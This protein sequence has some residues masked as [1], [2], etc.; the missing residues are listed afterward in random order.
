[1]DIKN[2]TYT[3]ILSLGAVSSAIA[4]DFAPTPANALPQHLEKQQSMFDSAVDTVDPRQGGLTVKHTDLSIPGPKGLNI[5]VHRNYSLREVSA[6]LQNSTRDS[7]AW[8][9]LGAGWRLDVAPVLYFDNTYSPVY[10]SLTQTTRFF[11]HSPI[12]KICTNQPADYWRRQL[13]VRLGT[14]EIKT[15]YISKNNTALSKD[16]WRLTCKN[17]NLTLQSPDGI[18]HDFGNYK[19]NR[20]IGYYVTSNLYLKEFQPSPTETYVNAIKSY[21]NYGNWITYTYQNFGTPRNSWDTPGYARPS[22]D[23]AYSK[24]TGLEKDTRLLSS[25]KSNDG[26]IV[27][28]N[29]NTSS[30]RLQKISDNAGRLITY[31][32]S[33]R[34]ALNGA[35]LNQV[36]LPSGQTWKYTYQPGPFDL[37]KGMRTPFIINPLN[38]TTVADRKLKKITYP[39]GG[40]VTYD[41]TFVNLKQMY[42][43][44]CKGTRESYPLYLREERIARRTLSSG[45]V[46]N[47]TF[48]R[49]GTGK[50]DTTTTSGPDGVHTQTFH[51][52]GYA[53]ISSKGCSMVYTDTIWRIGSPINEVLPGNQTAKYDWKQRTIVNSYDRTYELGMAVDRQVWAADLASKTVV[54]DG[55]SYTNSF[56]GYDTY[57]NPSTHTETGPNGGGR[58]TTYTWFNLPAKWIIG[59]PESENFPG[60]S[61]TRTF[62]D[63]GNVLSENHNGVITN[64]TYDAQGNLASKTLPGKRVFTFSNYKRGIPQ[65]EVQPEGIRLTRVVDNA[66]NITSQ[67]NGEGKTTAYTYDGLG[68]VTSITPPVGNPTSITYTATSKTSKRGAL[69]EITQYDP[70]GRV[71]SVT[72]G[73]IITRYEYDAMGRQTFVSDPGATSGTRYKYDSLGRL[74]R[75]THADNTFK[76][77]T[78]GAGSRSVTDERGK[79]TTYTYR[80]YGNPEKLQLMAINAPETS[81]NV[82]LTRNTR[83]QVTAVKQGPFTR[84]YVYNANGYLVSVVNPETGTTR[85][86]RDAAGNMTSRQIDA[87]GVTRYTYDGQNRLKTTTY[88]GTTPAISNAYDKTG[89]LLTSTSTGGNRSMAYDAA[90]NLLQETLT[91]DG[92]AFTAKYTYNANDQLSSMTYPQSERLVNYT[93]DLLGRPTTVSGYVNAITY[94]PSGMIRQI[95]Y[96][97]G[98]QSNYTQNN[99]LW[100][101][102]FT[103]AKT[104]GA[105]YLESAYSYDGSGNLLSIK[106]SIDSTFNRTLGYDGIH[107]LTSAAGFWGAGA[108]SYDGVGNLLK[109][110][111]GQST[112]NYAYDAQNR[113]SSVSGQRAASFGY[114]AYGNIA[115]STGISYAY[116][117]VPNLVCIN[118]AVPASKVEYQ[119]DA[120]NLRSAVSK[121]GRKVYEMHDSNGKQLIE[122]DGS[123]LT[124][125]FYLGD[126]RIAD[127]VSP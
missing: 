5:E 58:T 88:P 16:N 9:A 33:I 112:L 101:A 79:V 97:N 40:T 4:S 84:N 52:A 77:I 11:Y 90:G 21:D 87:S 12:D 96:V 94:W 107:R 104:G 80:G 86:G 93:P 126:R 49:G 99:R 74:T 120:L 60:N 41:Y 124:E 37:A 102:S 55:A 53:L 63:N 98:T 29:Y 65:V 18:S 78:Y 69:I 50:P 109:Q 115:S 30:G 1:M 91:L 22:A 67:T 36:T 34:D 71:A 75:I 23:P 113:L 106:D 61:I 64:F 117:D 14:G 119:Y 35:F 62:D 73:G 110:S 42:S 105:S 45:A 20:K 85:Y 66:G 103:T 56:S 111:L 6:G 54:R 39:T 123:S 125:Y 83:D 47:Y 7:Y 95:N 44:T 2:L 82:T 8:T 32:Y 108:I 72:L 116:N 10:N 81:A 3:V 121:A 27:T 17:W 51:S 48:S 38:N 25:I 122:L 31:D 43:T 68:R 13:Q 19:N 59:R 100:P 127:R 28:L 92:K 26:R 118:C 15:L 70:F 89:K 57:G 76:A 114:D 46:W 24:G